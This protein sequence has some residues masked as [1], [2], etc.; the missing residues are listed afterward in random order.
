LLGKDPPTTRAVCPQRC[1][2][3]TVASLSR[4]AA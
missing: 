1:T 2:G 3:V 4:V